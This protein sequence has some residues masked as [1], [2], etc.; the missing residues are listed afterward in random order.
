MMARVPSSN[1]AESLDSKPARPRSLALSALF[2]LLM[3]ISYMLSDIPELRAIELIEQRARHLEF[4]DQV[5]RDAHALARLA[6][7]YV[8]TGDADSHRAYQA[9]IEAQNGATPRRRPLHVPHDHADFDAEQSPAGP[10]APQSLADR[11]S[12]LDFDALERKDL[13]IALAALAESRAIESAAMQG[14]LPAAIDQTQRQEGWLRLFSEDYASAQSRVVDALDA[15][16]AGVDKRLQSAFDDALALREWWHTTSLLAGLLAAWFGFQAFR[17]SSRSLARLRREQAFSDTVLDTMGNALVVLDSGGRIVLV[18]QAVQNLTGF[19]SSELEGRHLWDGL[20]PDDQVPRV[21]NLIAELLQGR[22]TVQFSNPLLTR[23]GGRRQIQW[24]HSLLHDA[25]GRVSHVI[26]IGSDVTDELAM[27]DELAQAV[28]DMMVTMS[29]MDK[30]GIGVE[31]VEADT[32][33]FLYVSQHAAA[34]SGY[35]PEELQGKGVPEIDPD[36]SLDDIQLLRSR[37]GLEGITRFESLH[38]HRDG[39]MIPIEVTAYLQPAVEKRPEHFVS[40]IVDITERRHNEIELEG[41]RKD[42][43]RQ[44]AARTSELLH[45]NKQLENTLA[46]MDNADIGVLWADFASGRILFG[47]AFAAELLGY[48]ADELCRLYVWDIIADYSPNRH[49]EMCEQMRG[50]PFVTFESLHR[51]AQDQPI[52]IEVTASHRPATAAMPEHFVAFV[53][54]LSDQKRA[55]AARR[56]SEAKLQAVIKATQQGVWDWDLRSGIARLSPRYWEMAGYREGE[57]ETDLEFFRAT[58]HPEDWERVDGVIQGCLGAGGEFSEL[59]FRMIRA[60]GET[61]WVSD[62]G[63]VTERGEQG[64]PLRFVGAI[65]D[66][67]ERKTQEQALQTKTAQLETILNYSGIGIALIE[68][69]VTR[70]VNPAFESLFG[71][72]P[73]E[74][75]GRTAT[76]L[77]PVGEEFW[78]FF[79]LL[80]GE[81]NQNRSVA[82]DMEV[83]HRDGRRLWV[84]ATFDTVRDAAPSAQVIVFIEDVSE[85]KRVEERHR[86]LLEI[87]EN[88]TDC[89][90]VSDLQTRF[91]YLNPA[92][93]RLL[94]L[95]EDIDATKWY[96]VDACSKPAMAQFHDTIVPKLYEEG[97]WS[98]ELTLHHG[99]GE[100]IPVSTVALLHRDPQGTPT[101]YSCIHRDI[102]VEKAIRANLIE[103]KEAA[104]SGTR[105]KSEFLANMSHEIRTPLNAV[106]GYLQLLGSTSMK[107]AQAGYVTK[108]FSSSNLLHDLLSN[109]L[110]FSKIEAGMLDLDSA[111][112]DLRRLIGEIQEHFRLPAADKGLSL[113][114]NVAESC[115]ET[116]LG[117]AV[118]LRQVLINL[119]SNAIKFTARGSVTVSISPVPAGPSDQPG[120]AAALRFEVTD[121]GIGIEPEA[122]SRLFERFTQADSSTTRRFGGTGLGL[123]IVQ[124]LVQLMD[125]EIQADSQPDKGSSFCFTASFAIWEDSLPVEAV[126]PALGPV[127]IGTADLAGLRVLV[128]EDNPVNQDMIREILSL[129]G[130]DAELVSDGRQAVD[131]ITQPG[132]RYDLVLMDV[133]MPVMDGLETTRCLRREHGL[134]ELPIIAVTANVLV[135]ERQDC[136][137]AGMDDFLPKPISITELH[138]LIRKYCRHDAQAPQPPAPAASG[139][140]DPEG[141]DLQGA[142]ER[143]GGKRAT[144]RRLVGRFLNSLD[145][146]R[147]RLRALLPD[148]S[149]EATAKARRELHALRGSALT[150]GAESLAATLKTIEKALEED[151]NQDRDLLQ[152]RVED[153][154][155][156]ALEGFRQIVD[157]PG[158]DAG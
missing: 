37:I 23:A 33:R 56:D 115:P 147:D 109:L 27:K 128:A 55:E 151:A 88:S 76:F 150:L 30:A 2:V 66:I 95:P 79:R 70:W 131:R 124:S 153:A 92:G 19:A 7:T 28:G 45:A 141:F 149:G 1:P 75:T 157:K 93:R 143:L 89:I 57:V 58:V 144:Y 73:A 142:I 110:D 78:D 132:A 129:A 90:L 15:A 9:I 38:R 34:I 53:W 103:A 102:R 60:D 32:G 96:L 59:E 63:T 105:A 12:K 84:R 136:L 16:R 94:G 72:K 112:F 135:S 156:Q 81:L 85:R 80:D 68:N 52:P 61:L 125:G 127:D 39:R 118:R 13:Q 40:F 6:Q 74:L 77:S 152:A 97:H 99:A 3:V 22:Q 46:A 122:L 36:F 111:P 101:H 87:L 145:K 50:Q 8:A 146:P 126:R 25:R 18:N 11:L 155:D 86:L 10:T 116:L 138:G 47:S 48:A 82:R 4:I 98:G 120:T 114:L 130:A 20:I 91:N 43:E 121:T 49:R 119:V 62:S 51:T 83:R 54:D 5:S 14:A 140:G 123:S 67:T 21:R 42:L 148:T 108:A 154:I 137:D 158:P 71:Y 139:D 107:P 133:Q 31:W 44:V 35:E 65:T 106:I 64:E 29:A 117:D 113:R 104:E 69:R 100:T 134:S 26:N 24:Q 17:D 41:Y